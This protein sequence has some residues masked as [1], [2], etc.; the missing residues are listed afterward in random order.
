ME[1]L[2]N[3]CKKKEV[4]HENYLLKFITKNLNST[5]NKKYLV[6]L[7]R[8]APHLFIYLDLSK[9]VLSDINSPIKYNAQGSYEFIFNIYFHQPDLN[10]CDYEVCDHCDSFICPIHLKFNPMKYKKCNYCPKTWCICMNCICS[11]TEKN[12]CNKIHK[13]INEDLEEDMFGIILH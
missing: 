6:I 13:L 9:T 3:M 2:C 4:I 11:N 5:K 1:N 7:Y 8:L 12:L 10:V